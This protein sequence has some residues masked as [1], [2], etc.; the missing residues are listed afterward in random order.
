MDRLFVDTNIVIDLLQKREKF[1]EDA[2][3]LFTLAD[4]KKVKL[5]VSALTIANTHFVLSKHY[6][7]NNARKILAKFKLLVEVLA[8]NDKIIEWALV[9]DLKD[10][11]DAIQYHTA[12]ESNLDILITRNKRDFTKRDISILTAKEYLNRK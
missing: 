4:K 1:Y 9:S 5:F 10:F 8:L 3:E 12:I 11:E 7:S 6:H 2:Q